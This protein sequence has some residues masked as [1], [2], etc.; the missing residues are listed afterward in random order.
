MQLRRVQVE[1]GYRFQYGKGV[2][3]TAKP[4]KSE[5]LY[6]EYTQYLFCLITDH[7]CGSQL[8]A[9]PEPEESPRETGKAEIGKEPHHDFYLGR[10]GTIC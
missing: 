1:A 4:I 10:V 6:F 3:I 8:E 5:N 9:R 7:M 2:A